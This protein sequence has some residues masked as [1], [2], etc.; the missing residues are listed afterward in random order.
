DRR[1]GGVARHAAVVGARHPRPGRPAL[2]QREV[3]DRR[4]RRAAGE[5]RRPGVQ[6]DRGVVERYQ[7]AWRLRPAAA[8]R[9]PGVTGVP[10]VPRV[11]WPAF[12]T[13][14]VGSD[15]VPITVARFMFPSSLPS[16]ARGT[17]TDNELLVN[18]GT[19]VPTS[20]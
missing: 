9:R 8:C 7:R 13:T 4:A 10:E 5:D 1:Q 16:S 18:V 6:E 19:T 14:S 11:T 15:S 20:P 3:R 12:G 2:R 17:V